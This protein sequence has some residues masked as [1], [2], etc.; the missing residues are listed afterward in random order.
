MIYTG[1]QLRQNVLAFVDLVKEMS[2]KGNT[3]VKEVVSAVK[4]VS[5][6]DKADVWSLAS[7]RPI[8]CGTS[9]QNQVFHLQILSSF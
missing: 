4:V 2:Q 8:F 1:Q 9:D 7:V 6:N 3:A 5:G